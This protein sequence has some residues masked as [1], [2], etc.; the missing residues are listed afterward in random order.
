M[1][2]IGEKA[3]EIQ[4][5]THA[6]EHFTLSDTLKKGP[7]VLFFYPKDFTPVCSKEVCAFRDLSS[8]LAGFSGQIVGVSADSSDSHTSFAQANRLNYPLLS[9]PNRTIAN[10]YKAMYFGMLPKRVTYVIGQDGRIREALHNEFSA[11][12][13]VKRVKKALN[14]P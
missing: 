13:H 2:K 9:D 12:K 4:G 10:D 5:Q 14:L 1:L 6:G 3:P 8:E 7:V 11:E